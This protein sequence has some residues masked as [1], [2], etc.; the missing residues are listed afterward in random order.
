M[1]LDLNL[2]MPL[3]VI[4]CLLSIPCYKFQIHANPLRSTAQ[5]PIIERY[6]FLISQW[7]VSFLPVRNATSF[8]FSAMPPFVAV[9]NLR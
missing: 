9:G 6:S 4:Y 8:S 1:N 3:P 7:S 2:N 5:L